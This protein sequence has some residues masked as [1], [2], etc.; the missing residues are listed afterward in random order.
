MPSIQATKARPISEDEVDELARVLDEHEPEGEERAERIARRGSLERE[1]TRDV[2]GVPRREGEDER[3]GEDG[4]RREVA[5]AL[6]EAPR[7]DEADP[8]GHREGEAPAVQ[9]RHRG[10]D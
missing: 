10:E 2:G 9:S 1:G 8:L 7:V 5:R 6:G 3:E 4:E